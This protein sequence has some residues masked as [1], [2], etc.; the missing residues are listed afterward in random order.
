MLL[1]VAEVHLTRRDELAGEARFLFQHAE[2]HPPGGAAELVAAGALE[3]ADAVLGAH[4]ISTLDT[5]KAAVLDGACTAA[6]DTFSVTVHGRGGHAAF[7]HDAVDPVA[8][9]AQAISNLQHIVS[10]TT[11]PLER[12]VV[13]VTRIAAGSAD[14]VIPE[15][16]EFGG[17]VRTYSQEVRDHA[18]DAIARIMSGVTSAHGA[19]FELNYPEGYDPVVN[20]PHLA[21]LVREAAGA[22]R[23]VQSDPVMAGED[24]SAY[25]RVAPGCFFFIGAGNADAF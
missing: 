20:D 25:L 12:I 13:S 14:N 11:S 3:G 21:S 9:A 22:E 17:T 4:L 15:R 24:F 5:G 1:A 23:M 18:R 10:R 6:S 2:E 7:P 8:V 19:T 16:A